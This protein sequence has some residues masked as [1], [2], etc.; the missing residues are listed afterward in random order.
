MTPSLQRRGS[1]TGLGCEPPLDPTAVAW[2]ET[3]RFEITQPRPQPTFSMSLTSY[4]PGMAQLLTGTPFGPQTRPL[5]VRSLSL[6]VLQ[7]F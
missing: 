5:Y 7:C 1:E 4:S 2:R 3:E 6:H